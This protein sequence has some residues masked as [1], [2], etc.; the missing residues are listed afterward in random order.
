MDCQ[1]KYREYLNSDRR[2]FF[3]GETLRNRG[4]ER[5]SAFESYNRFAADNYSILKEYNFSGRM[6]IKNCA[7]LIYGNT[8][9]QK[10]MN[11]SLKTDES[12]SLSD[13]FYSEAADLLENNSKIISDREMVIIN[14]KQSA[15]LLRYASLIVNINGYAK[16]SFDSIDPNVLFRKMA[17]SF[18]HGVMWEDIFPS[19]PE[20]ARNIFKNRSAIPELLKENRLQ[21]KTE[22][23]AGD[24]LDITEISSRDDNFSI[25][26]F[27]FYVINWLRNFG[28]VEIKGK[29]DSELLSVSE[30]GIELASVFFN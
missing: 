22:D 10:L 14:L 11:E 3:R 8:I 13:A 26:F 18:W 1:K 20:L 12:C 21:V 23:F 19:S 25:S 17:D 16:P 15:Q 29:A 28:V 7:A 2:L 4:V 9:L 30:Y 24:F 5:L 6:K 27:E